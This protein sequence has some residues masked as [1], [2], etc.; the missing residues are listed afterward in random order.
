MHTIAQR[1]LSHETVRRLA[2][3]CQGLDGRSAL[4]P[5]KEGVAQ[6]IERLGYVQIDTISVVQRAH[7][8]T[9]WSRCPDYVPSMLHDLQAVDRRVFEWW[10]PAMSVLPMRHYR[11][12]LPRMRAAAQR[13][14]R[15]AWVAEHQ[16]LIDRVLARI[17]DEGPLGSRDFKAPEGFVRGDWWSWKPAKRALEV[18][19]DSGELMVTERR[20]FQRIYDLRERVLPPE[21]DTTEPDADEMARYEVR[22]ALGAYGLAPVDDIRWRRRGNP[23]PLA[24]A[25]RAM[26]EEGEV[27]L[28]RVE[29]A[30]GVA[31]CALT[32][33]LA[34]VAGA[35]A[36][37]P[38]LHILS[39]FDSMVIR[40]PWLEATFDFRYRLEA[41]T[42]AAKRQ[43]GYFALPI[44]WGD[45]FVGRVDAKADR[46]ARRLLLRRL[47]LE[48]G[49]AGDGPLIAALVPRL[50]AFARFNGCAHVRVGETEPASFAAPLQ[51]ALDAAR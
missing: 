22:R 13:P 35:S 32:A 5:G 30:G 17:R 46:R 14:R 15:R 12:Y 25:A 45:A 8:H 6:A 2:L 51:R 1:P 37:P 36:G 43:Y 50:W 21:V 47:T 4:P 34:A 29:G 10:A 11:Y 24:R 7:H 16:L 19:F 42:P 20:S 26:A 23:A 40:R 44:L 41:Y 49:V 39:P 18:L 31:Y 48:P 28:L 3:Y 9:L 27:T 33:V 38:Q